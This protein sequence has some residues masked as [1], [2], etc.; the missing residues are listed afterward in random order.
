MSSKI[1]SSL[2]LAIAFFPLKATNIYSKDSAV[3]VRQH[4]PDKKYFK[5]CKGK[6]I[7]IIY[8]EKW[9]A[10]TVYLDG[11]INGQVYVTGLLDKTCPAHKG[12][13]RMVSNDS[14]KATLRKKH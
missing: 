10:T 3:I 12:I 1:Y 13:L 8:N 5:R 4:G 11:K 2:L 7:I 9:E 6:D 14:L